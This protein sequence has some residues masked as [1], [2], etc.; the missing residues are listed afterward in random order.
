MGSVSAVQPFRERV[1]LPLFNECAVKV[2]LRT[3]C[4][5]M[6]GSMAS[7]MRNYNTNH[8]IGSE[9]PP[10]AGRRWTWGLEWLNIPGRGK[11]LFPGQ[12]GANGRTTVPAE[13]YPSTVWVMS[14]H[15][16]HT[17]LSNPRPWIFTARTFIIEDD[18]PPGSSWVLECEHLAPATP[19]MRDPDQNSP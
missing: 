15:W 19:Q 8:P 6:T 13:S 1:C 11:T 2:S 14:D 18:S 10:V 7:A 16:N 9:R 4:V 12:L 3:R 17:E 5:G